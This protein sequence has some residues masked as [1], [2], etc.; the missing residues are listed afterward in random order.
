[1]ADVHAQCEHSHDHSHAHDP[2]RAHDHAHAAPTSSKLRAAVLLTIAFVVCELIAGYLAHSLA[3]L[4]DAGHN[5]ADAAALGFS[6]Y[7][8]WIA[9][10][11]AHEGM[12]YGYHRVG[13]LAAFVNAVSLVI[14]ALIIFYEAIDRLRH[15]QP[16]RGW[17]MIFVA[18]GAI[19]VNVIISLWLHA[20]A[21][22][23]LNIRSA[24]M[25]MIGDAISAFGVV[26]AGVVVL[27]IGWQ[28][29]DPMVS[30]LIAGLILLSSWGILRES[31]NV[32][33]EGTPAGMNMADVVATIQSVPGVLGAHDLHVWTIGPGAVAC[34]VHILVT[35]Q[36]IREGQQILQ[37]VVSM[38]QRQHRINHAT[39][40]VEVEG[41]AVNEM[42][43]C[44]EGSQHVGHRH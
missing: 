10:K 44:I 18:A 26:L 20:G 32:L 4:A 36:T 42:Y 11:P 35:E 3:L 21:K 28:S 13:I 29:A 23:D 19:A 31:V 8:V 16:A 5:F 37:A 22:H 12:T 1:M 9:R 14:T 30:F 17:L 38:L 43:C 40:Q 39:V 15:P 33:L 6:W 27:T 25:H 41:H 34:S 7:A 24:Y 2:P